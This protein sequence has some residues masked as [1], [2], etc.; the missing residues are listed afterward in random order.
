MDKEPKGTNKSE[1]KTG[2]THA[3]VIDL[4]AKLSKVKNLKG[5]ELNYAIKK[6]LKNLKPEIEIYSE[7]EKEIQEITKDFID[8]TNN[9][10]SEYATVDGKVKL[11]HRQDGDKTFTEYDVPAEKK[12]ELQQKIEE[13]RKKHKA[14][15]DE[16]NDK[17]KDLMESRKTGRTDFEIFTVKKQN[18]PADISTEDMELIFDL[19][20][21]DE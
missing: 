4:N 1:K 21:E 16:A 15:L 19:I 12:K 13:L 6:N 14:K 10:K 18:V 7:Q 5:F 8:E 11:K 2:M 9:L 3:E 20:K 17:W